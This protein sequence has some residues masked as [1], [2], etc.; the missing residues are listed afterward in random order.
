[1]EELRLTVANG[2]LHVPV[3]VKPRASR[4]RVLGCKEGCLEVAVAA[5][6]VEGL[7]NR[8]LLRELARRLKVPRSQLNLVSG[9]TGRHK[10]VAVQGVSAERCR[11]LLLG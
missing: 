5:P 9:K 4:T 2:V 8:E 3:R 10:R 7:A 11:A 6:P 1:M